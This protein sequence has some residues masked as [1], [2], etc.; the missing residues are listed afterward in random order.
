MGAQTITQEPVT[1][2][3]AARLAAAALALASV[4]AIAGFTVLGSI[5]QY[6][7]ILEEPTSQILALFRE[8]QGAV[9]TWFLVLA[10]S[11]ALMA[12]AGVFL[13]RLVGGTLGAWIAR[14]GI[15]AAAVQVIGLLRWAT[16]VPGVSQEAL[17][18]TRRADAEAR[19]ELLHNLLG[20]LIGETFG[21]ALTATFTVLVVVAL[22]RT[23]L[24]RWMAVIGVAAA[25]LIATGVVIPLVEAAS[26]SNFAGY[27]VWCLW[28]LGVAALLLRAPTPTVTATSI[29]PT[30][31]GRRFTGRRP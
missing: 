7:Q 12:P 9:V 23:I 2:R 19:F 8:R 29:T 22:G 16:V 24:P 21:Y 18:P 31:W 11:A 27:V 3:S 17:D 10:L 5:F 26:L 4:L 1:H 15:A 28:L 13:G 25:A 20:R 30:A 6:P 14:V